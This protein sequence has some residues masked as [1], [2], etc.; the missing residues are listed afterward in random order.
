VIVGMLAMDDLVVDLTG[1]L[2]RLTRPTAGQVC[3]GHQ[4]P[5]APA[6]PG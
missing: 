2:A 6:M 5:V 3:F 4:E 1:D